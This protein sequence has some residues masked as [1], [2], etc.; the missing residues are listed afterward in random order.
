MTWQVD[1]LLYAE[2]YLLSSLQQLR[3]QLQFDI[4]SCQMLLLSP[5]HFAFL[6]SFSTNLSRTH[7]TSPTSHWWSS[8]SSSG[9]SLFSQNIGNNLSLMAAIN[10]SLPLWGSNKASLIMSTS[11]SDRSKKK[12]KLLQMRL[13]ALFKRW[14]RLKWARIQVWKR[15]Y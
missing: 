14:F 1:K 8:F 3:V 13:L 11:L 15:R 12:W 9:K 5:R 7:S 10:Q 4:F 6:P 2:S